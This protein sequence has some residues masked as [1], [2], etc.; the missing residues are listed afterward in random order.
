MRQLILLMGMGLDGIGA[1]GWIPRI[2]NEVDAGELHDEMWS[3]L[4]AIDTFLMGRRCFQLWERVW[5]PLAAD[6]RSSE[7]EKDFSRFTDRTQKVVFSRTLK[8]VGWQN[9][10][11]VTGNVAA[12]VARMKQQPGKSMAIVGGPSIAQTFSE[13]G[14]IDEYLLWLH[15]VIL[16]K[17]T[18]L[19]G[20]LDEPRALKLIGTKTF[21]S[22]CVSLQLR[23]RQ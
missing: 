15:P 16:G 6:P 2:D 11:L 12:E 18:P 8:S 3:Q 5:P 13:L 4:K 7:F 1:E 20:A 10:R 21:K 14:V 17:G 9:S 23:A 22:G 19:L